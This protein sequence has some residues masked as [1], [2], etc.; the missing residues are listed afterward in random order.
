MT[1]KRTPLRRSTSSTCAASACR[2][3]FSTSNST[4]MAMMPLASF[5]EPMPART[6]AAMTI[7]A[8][9]SVVPSTFC[10]DAT[11]Y[12][13]TVIA[14]APASRIAASAVP[15]VIQSHPAM[16]ASAPSMVKV[17]MPANLAAGPSAWPER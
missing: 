4:S 5:I 16:P 13:E 6:P 1:P 10:R 3:L 11:M 15:P 9:T 12:A 2:R 7:S 17:R 14:M 8:E